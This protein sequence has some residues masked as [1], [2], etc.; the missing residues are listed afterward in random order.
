M[1]IRL[2]VSGIIVA[3]DHSDLHKLENKPL[4]FKASFCKIDNQPGTASG[5][6]QVIQDL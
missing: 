2:D 5:N 1:K 3:T 4:V 6:L